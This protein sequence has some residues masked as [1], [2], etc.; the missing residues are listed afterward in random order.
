VG[1]E[2]II[3][4]NEIRHLYEDYLRCEN[5]K[6]KQMIHYDILSLVEALEVTEKQR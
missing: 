4:I 6:I 3:F 5:K 2:D 1:E